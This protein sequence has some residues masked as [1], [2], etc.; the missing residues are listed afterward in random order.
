MKV[1]AY[2]FE[3]V[4]EPLLSIPQFNRLNKGI[5]FP[6]ERILMMKN[7][8]PTTLPEINVFGDLVST[9]YLSK[10]S[11]RIEFVEEYIKSGKSVYKYDKR[12]IRNRLNLPLSSITYKELKKIQIDNK[13]LTLIGGLEGNQIISRTA[14]ESI[15]KIINKE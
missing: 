5:Y 3:E 9:Y 2:C 12:K 14:T 8:L 13:I 11:E 6:N 10:S 15:E 1:D 7:V 4:I